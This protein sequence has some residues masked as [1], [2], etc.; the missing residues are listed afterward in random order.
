MLAIIGLWCIVVGVALLLDSRRAKWWVVDCCGTNIHTDSEKDAMD[1]LAYCGPS[2][3]VLRDG[4]V[5]AS[6][7]K[8]V[9]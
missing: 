4:H 7:S 5:V 6:R 2:A 1:W 8:Q 3:W 9:V